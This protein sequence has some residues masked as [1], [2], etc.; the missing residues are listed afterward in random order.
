[1]PAR[2]GEPAPPIKLADAPG[3]EIDLAEVFGKRKA[4]ILFF[5]LAFSPVCTEEFCTF[6]DN[7]AKW[8]DLGCDVYGISVD[9]PFVVK[10]F[11]ET[12]NI[13]FPILSDFNKTVSRAYG[14]FHRDLFGMKGVSKRAAFVVDAAGNVVYRWVSNDP[15]KQ[16]KFDAIRRAVKNC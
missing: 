5:P 12:E 10:K 7:W 2:K 14:A 4:V 13:P 15:R 16:V 6:R 11:R 1:M 9:S 3:H 8:S